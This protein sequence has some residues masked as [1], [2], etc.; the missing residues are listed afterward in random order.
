M[1]QP[2]RTKR[3]VA[4]AFDIS[5]R[6]LPLGLSQWPVEAPDTINP[7]VGRECNQL[8]VTQLKKHPASKIF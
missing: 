4:N 6:Q 7:L 3:I 8:Q 5:S 2:H 1:S